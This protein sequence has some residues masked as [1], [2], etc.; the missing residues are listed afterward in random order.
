[1]TEGDPL[2]GL[3]RILVA[4]DAARHGEEIM[5]AAARLA[6]GLEAEL[7]G[8]FVEDPELMEAAA[9]PMAR[10][11]SSQA[12]AEAE[13]DARIMAR[14]LRVTAAQAR[15]TLAKVAERAHARWSFRVARG[16]LAESVLAELQA[17]DMVALI[18]AGREI[19]RAR[20]GVSARAVAERAPCSVLL[21]NVEGRGR[22]PVVVVYEGSPRTLAVAETLARCDGSPLGVVAA[23]GSPEASRRLAADASRWLAGRGLAADVRGLD[24]GDPGALRDALRDLA[25]RGLV[26]D[27]AGELARALDVE[28]LLRELPCSVVIVR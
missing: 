2:P 12:G 16:P 20:A 17:D 4:L 18:S 27:G 10:L 5:E 8:L 19:G 13:L 11:I 14:A 25:P 28:A 3:R 6:A 15:V 22:R 1:M 26:L 21:L 9:L 23:G 7:V 24:G